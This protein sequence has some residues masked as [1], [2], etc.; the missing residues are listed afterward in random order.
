[1]LFNFRSCFGFLSHFLIDNVFP[2]TFITTSIVNTAAMIV[3]N[4]IYDLPHIRSHH[5]LLSHH[6]HLRD[7]FLQKG[8]RC[9]E[10]PR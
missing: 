5:R 6:L 7:G 8:E 10:P 3:L 2:F 1:M 4:L 9:N